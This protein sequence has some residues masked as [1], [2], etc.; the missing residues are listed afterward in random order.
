L[1]WFE[2]RG[3]EPLYEGRIREF[4]AV[5][6][7]LNCWYSIEYDGGFFTKIPLFPFTP[8]VLRAQKTD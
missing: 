6:L 4:F 2:S 7:K 5:S 8:A 3:G 1:N